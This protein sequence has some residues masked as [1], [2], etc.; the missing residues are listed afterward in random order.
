MQLHG[1]G[2]A[3][4]S[5]LMRSALRVPFRAMRSTPR[6]P[7]ALATLRMAPRDSPVI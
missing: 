2:H 7:R 5:R 4:D 6:A 3:N 1:A